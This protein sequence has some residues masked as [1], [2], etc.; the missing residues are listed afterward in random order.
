VCLLGDGGLQFTLA[1]L[2]TAV[3][4]GARLI[5]ILL[6]NRGYG[7]IR[8]AMLARGIEPVGVDLHTPDFQAIARAYGWASESLDRPESLPNVVQRAAARTAPTLIEIQ[9]G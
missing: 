4:T 8:G 3:E 7:E 2:G 1:E 6:N 9:G 5:V